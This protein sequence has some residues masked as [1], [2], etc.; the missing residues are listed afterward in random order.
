MKNILSQLNH[1]IAELEN[2]GNVKQAE[3]LEK[4]FIK[5]ASDDILFDPRQKGSDLDDMMAKDHHNDIMPHGMSDD[6]ILFDPRQ[7]GSA[8]DDMLAKDP[9]VEPMKYHKKKIRVKVKRVK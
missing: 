5:I 8:L 7:K 9:H 6:D 4:I 2:K 1:V 3:N